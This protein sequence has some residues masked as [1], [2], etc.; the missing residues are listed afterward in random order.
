MKPLTK[1]DFKKLVD[2][3]TLI[4]LHKVKDKHLIEGIKNLLKPKA[5]MK[6]I[7]NEIKIKIF[8]SY[9]GC[10]IKVS[11]GLDRKLIAVGGYEDEPY[12]KL[13][14]GEAG[15]KQFVHSEFI[16]FYKSPIYLK[17]LLNITDE[18]AIEAIQM[19]V[20][21]KYEELKIESK[22]DDAVCY[23]FHTNR[24]GRLH[25]FLTYDDLRFNVY[26]YLQSKGYALTYMDY[27]VQDLVELEIYKLK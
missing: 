8:S 25:G 13:R 1:K 4:M 5:K 10:D 12:I 15:K 7:T 22:N 9:I 24:G 2:D 17:S 16:N 11:E 18:D 27:S 6:T 23:S 14:L 26:Q 20:T 19:N 3:G 21:E